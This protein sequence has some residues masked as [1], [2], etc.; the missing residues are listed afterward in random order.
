MAG[1]ARRSSRPVSLALGAVG[2]AAG[3]VGVSALREATMSTHD[4]VARDSRIEL[5]VDAETRG[6]ERSQ[7]TAEMVDAQIRTCRLEVHSDVVG[8]IVEMRRDRFRATLAPSMDESD[9]RQ[10][11]GCLE[12]WVVDGISLDVVW[13][14][15]PAS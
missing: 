8:D 7:T 2:L 1:A 3:V 10:F 5:V 11:R 15:E 6:R 9:R 14:A 12:D 13:L 4:T